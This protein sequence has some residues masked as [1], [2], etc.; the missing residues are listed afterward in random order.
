MFD[1]VNPLGLKGP[2]WSV[3]CLAAGVIGLA[4]AAVARGEA[5]RLI[6]P[7]L[8]GRVDRL[9]KRFIALARATRPAR[10]GR[11]GR[12]PRAG[13]RPR[14]RGMRRTPRAR[15]RGRYPSSRAT[16]AGSRG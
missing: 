13:R 12:L 15:A 3:Y 6:F 7:V 10:C 4:K 16:G 8:A 14:G 11:R 5:I 1:P 9:G 2:A